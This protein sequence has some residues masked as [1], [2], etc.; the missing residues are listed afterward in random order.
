MVSELRKGMVK[1]EG[2]LFAGGLFAY[3]RI[4]Q[5]RIIGLEGRGTGE[6]RSWEACREGVG[7]QV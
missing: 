1:S 2:V 6:A 5:L 7:C 4:P 3:V